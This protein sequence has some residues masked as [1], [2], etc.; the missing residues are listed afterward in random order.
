MKTQADPTTE[1][2][3]EPDEA[4]TPE[5]DD[6]DEALPSDE[7]DGLDGPSRFAALAL[8]A[9]E[10]KTT[11]VP[12]ARSE[13]EWAAMEEQLTLRLTTE[14]ALAR[15]SRRLQLVVG[16]VSTLALAA[17]TTFLIRPAEP[18][19]PADATPTLASVL[20]GGPRGAALTTPLPGGRDSLYEGDHVEVTGGPLAFEVP[21]VGAAVA[22]PRRAIWALD[23]DGEGTAKAVVTRATPT[24]LVI[25]LERGALEADV[26]PER[27]AEAFAVD[28]V[29]PAGTTR[30]AVHGT[31]LRVARKGDHVTV[32][33]TEGFLVVGAPGAG[34]TT[35][36]EVRAPAH[37]EFEVGAAAS[38]LQV[39]R[40]SRE[41]R[42][43]WPLDL[44]AAGQSPTPP[45]LPASSSPVG[46]EPS[47]TSAKPTAPPPLGSSAPEEPVT[48]TEARATAAIQ[49][50][51]KR[52]VAKATVP[53]AMRVSVESELSVEVRADG[54]V[55]GT[56]F[57]PPLAPAVQ[58]CASGAIFGRRI[59]GPR[60]LIIP[61][62]FEF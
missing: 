8:L 22:T 45:A 11:F 47:A 7:L 17:G 51:L 6:D 21:G 26:T 13:A 48:L 56:R 40:V 42:A 46:S 30:V 32:D 24:A 44:V 28:L 39:S 62:K 16:V 59:E 14:R 19:P 2:A 57:T 55:A 60:T 25:S 54:T 50:D 9:E 4:A 23:P 41:P 18:L 34:L 43:A 15:R 35:G 29:G 3:D 38:Q 20:K 36:L 5:A 49:V 53:G 58:E 52:C 61:V 33:L 37:V 12:R 1:R 10:A 31:H 27:A